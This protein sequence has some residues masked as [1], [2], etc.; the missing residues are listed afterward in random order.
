MR[1]LAKESGELSFTSV[2]I[3][4]GAKGGER[5]SRIHKSV[6]S[7]KP[8]ALAVPIVPMF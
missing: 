1:R 2:N 4:G 5:S 6:I 7:V 8:L 3:A